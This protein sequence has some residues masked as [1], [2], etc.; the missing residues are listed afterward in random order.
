MIVV[1]HRG[2][3]GDAPENTRASFV[4][5]LD[6][7]AEAVEFD[8][9]LTLDGE[10]VVFHD[11]TVNRTTDGRGTVA[12]FTLLALRR[13]DAGSWFHRRFSAERVPTLDEALG[14]CAPF[15]LINIEL[16][17][18]GRSRR[19]DALLVE[20]TVDA[21]RRSRLEK[22]VI[23]SSFHHPLLRLVRFET[24]GIRTMAITGGILHRRTVPSTVVVHAGAS[25]YVGS[26]RDITMRKLRNAR[27]HGIPVFVYTLNTEH[28]L[29]RW[30]SRDIAGIITNFP[31]EAIRVRKSLEES[32][33]AG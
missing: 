25:G 31:S 7:G 16:K 24:P 19:S 18:G 23:V 33:D 20:R 9:R 26:K 17:T 13:L 15:Q 22:K 5:A 27:E 6:S 12:A 8:V 14:F 10:A 30:M 1:A 21:V 28:E 11:R 32:A 2:C 3:S 29:R 4:L